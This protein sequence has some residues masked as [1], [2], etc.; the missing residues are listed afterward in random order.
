MHFFK[1]YFV[2]TLF[3]A[4]FRRFRAVFPKINLINRGKNFP[5][6]LPNVK[7]KKVPQRFF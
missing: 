1:F 7:E 4:S 5:G 2:N 3:F 6:I